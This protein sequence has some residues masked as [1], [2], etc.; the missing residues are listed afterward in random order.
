LKTKPPAINAVSNIFSLF[1]FDRLQGR[2]CG[3]TETYHLSR[4]SREQFNDKWQTVCELTLSSA[5]LLYSAVIAAKIGILFGTQ[6]FI[7]FRVSSDAALNGGVLRTVLCL[8]SIIFFTLVIAHRD[9]LTTY[10]EEGEDTDEKI[11]DL[12][13]CFKDRLVG[14]FYRLRM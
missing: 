8:S 11:S 1:T 3:G 7:I 14:T 10:D 2:C 9:A 5:W 4:R 6:Q 12:K 13:E